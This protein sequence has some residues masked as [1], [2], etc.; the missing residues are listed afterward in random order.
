MIL[1]K[2]TLSKK[3]AKQYGKRFL[4]I[5]IVHIVEFH[6]IIV[7]GPAKEKSY[8]GTVLLV[9]KNVGIGMQKVYN[10]TQ[11]SAALRLGTLRFAARPCAS[12]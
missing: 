9:A 5:L 4:K 6:L 2:I 7:M 12:R 11:Q 1:S 3:L 8:I 10:I